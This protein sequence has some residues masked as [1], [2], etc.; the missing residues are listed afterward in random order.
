MP[1][2]LT[3][4]VALLVFGLTYSYAAGISIWK[5]YQ[6]I[7]VQQTKTVIIPVDDMNFMSKGSYLGRWVKQVPGTRLSQLAKKYDSNLDLIRKVNNLKWDAVYYYRTQWLFIPYS[8]SSLEQLL[9]SEVQ[10]TY[11]ETSPGEMI[12]PVNGE[13]LTSGVGQRWGRKH[14]GLDIAAPIGTAVVAANDGIVQSASSKG[15][16]GNTVE[17]DHG[18][19]VFT[20]YAHLQAYFVEKNEVVRKGQIIGF[21]GNSG[22]S[23]GPHLHFEVRINQIVLNPEMFLPEFTNKTT[24][25][26]YNE[27]L[28]NKN[29]AINL[30]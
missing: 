9:A 22:F 7:S 25:T 15:G 10:R 1:R 17:L 21:S 11:I 13:R 4:A 6:D 26:A 14:S 3:F 29:S 2:F 24:A 23:T 16:F 5:R 28:Q 12:W 8:E 18:Q 27:F 30:K 20:R 19:G